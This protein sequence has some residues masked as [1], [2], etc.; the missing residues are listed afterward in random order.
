M[1]VT[2]AAR[3]PGTW[4]RRSV[5][6][7]SSWS[8]R[9]RRWRSRSPRPGQRAFAGS[10]ARMSRFTA[11]RRW[12]PCL[13]S[14]PPGERVGAAREFHP[15]AANFSS[16]MAHSDPSGATIADAHGRAGWR[17]RRSDY[18]SCAC[19]VLSIRA[20]RS[21][22]NDARRRSLLDT[23]GTRLTL[24]DNPDLIDPRGV[25]APAVDGVVVIGYVDGGA[26]A[27]AAGGARTVVELDPV[28][29]LQ[30]SMDGSAVPSLEEA[31]HAGMLISATGALDDP[32]LS[33]LG[34]GP[35]ATSRSCRR[36]RREVS[37]DRPAVLGS[38]PSRRSAR[39]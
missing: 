33:A 34:G 24:D 14:Q 23:Y 11:R 29:A 25:G 32:A 6:L 2:E 21:W 28:R 10:S 31:P 19:C 4:L 3:A 26:A 12:S 20:F 5:G 16:M 15:S 36:G 18:L 38:W 17:R 13:H 27:A 1:P 7:S 22:P 30:A 37:T 39:T 9:P 35:A 8:R